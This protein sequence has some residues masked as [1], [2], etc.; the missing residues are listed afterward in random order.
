MD[1]KSRTVEEKIALIAGRAYGVVTRAEML[2]AGIT[3][4]EIR[5]R[6]E[7]GQL[8]RQHRGVYLDTLARACHEDGVRYRTTP[9][10]VE[11]VL[12]RRR[13]AGKSAMITEVS[14]LVAG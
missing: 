8:I 9:R 5:R 4:I 1:P 3:A 10:Q 2:R 6:A 12:G 11:E 14:G 13:G 7:K